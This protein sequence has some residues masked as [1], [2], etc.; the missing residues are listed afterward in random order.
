MHT[1]N[2][3]HIIPMHFSVKPHKQTALLTFPEKMYRLKTI[4]RDKQIQKLVDGFYYC[5]KPLC[6]HTK[7]FFTNFLHATNR[8]LLS[9]SRVVINGIL[10]FVVENLFVY[11]QFGNFKCCI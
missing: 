7:K 11:L 8:A 5:K 1:G 4:S 3:T 6:D 9:L 10:H 2:I